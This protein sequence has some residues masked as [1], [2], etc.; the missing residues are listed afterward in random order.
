MSQLL[1]HFGLDRHPFSRR[2]PKEA[3]YRHRGF[4]EASRRLLFTLRA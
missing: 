4:E 3:L 1:R 2:T